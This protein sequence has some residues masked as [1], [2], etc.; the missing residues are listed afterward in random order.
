MPKFGISGLWTSKGSTIL[1]ALLMIADAVVSY[2][3]SVSLPP[4]VH[5]IVVAVGGLL[6][7]YKG[8]IASQAG[9]TP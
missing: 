6:A 9:Q 2:A 1:G 3:T 5:L 7:L 8:K 4:V